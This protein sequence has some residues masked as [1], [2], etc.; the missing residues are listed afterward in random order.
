MNLLKDNT[1]SQIAWIGSSAPFIHSVIGIPVGKL[2][3]G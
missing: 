3:D 1:V 2:Y